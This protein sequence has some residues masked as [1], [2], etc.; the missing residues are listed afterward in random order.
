M[1]SATRN[2]VPRGGIEPS[3]I[4]PIRACAAQPVET[5]RGGKTGGH[6]ETGANCRNVG[7]RR[8][9]ALVAL[10]ALAACDDRIDL[11]GPP[12]PGWRKVAPYTEAFDDLEA[13]VRCYYVHSVGVSCV[14]VSP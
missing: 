8:R 9:L 10:I 1:E 3:L 2:P 13:G 7:S 11:S 4:L 14:R 12:L 5:L 6:S